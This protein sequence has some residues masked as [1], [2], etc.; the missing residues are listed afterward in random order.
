MKPLVLCKVPDRDPIVF[1]FSYF[2]FLHYKVSTPLVFG[3]TDV[4]AAVICGTAFAFVV[5]GLQDRGT[6]LRRPLITAEGP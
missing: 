3:T 6:H 4:G 2:K 1:W 5:E